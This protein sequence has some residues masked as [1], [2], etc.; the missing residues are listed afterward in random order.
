M[1]GFGSGI[2]GGA[3]GYSRCTVEDSFYLDAYAMLPVIFQ[4]ANGRSRIGKIWWTSH[5]VKE[6]E[7]NYSIDGKIFTL[8]YTLNKTNEIKYAVPLVETR[9]PKGG[10]RYWFK[11]PLRTCGRMTAKLYLPKGALYFACR[12]CYNLTYRS[13]NESHLFD[14]FHGVLANY[15][16]LSLEQTKAGLKKW[17]KAQ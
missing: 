13:C 8:F 10:A 2:R 14:K 3:A 7:I 12:Q 9:Q 15:C 4:D 1:G 6:A 16:G 11:C 5:G 17:R